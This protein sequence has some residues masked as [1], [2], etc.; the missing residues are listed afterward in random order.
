MKKIKLTQNKY[1]IVDDENFNHLNI[2]K[3]LVSKKSHRY[4][5]GRTV[6]NK[7]TKTK[8]MVYM[9]RYILNASKNK[10]VDHINGNTL[11]NRKSNL[12]LCSNTENIR[13][14]KIGLRNKTG[15]KGVCKI[16]RSL[17][18]R[19]LAQ[20]NIKG[21][22]TKLGYFKTAKEAAVAYNKAAIKHYKEFAKINEKI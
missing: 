14:S 12:R 1:T 13:N 11:D 4:Y 19:Y 8:R 2:F 18:K 22:N 20:I 16:N 5:A 21:K 15:Y 7:K 10:V 9:A 3:W 6:W 17:T